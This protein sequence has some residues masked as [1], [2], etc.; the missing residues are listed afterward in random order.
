MLNKAR[1][2][3]LGDTIWLNPSKKL[4][5]FHKWFFTPFEDMPKQVFEEFKHHSHTHA[6][7]T[8]TSS[9]TSHGDSVATGNIICGASCSAYGHSHTAT[10]GTA[11][12]HTHSVTLSFGSANLGS[13]NWYEHTHSVAMVTCGSGGTIHTHTLPAS[14]TANYCLICGRTHTHSH[15]VGTL[16]V[17]SVDDSHTHTL[18]LNQVTG[19]A[20]SSQTPD[21]HQHPFSTGTT[22]YQDATHPTSGQTAAAT[23]YKGCSHTQPYFSQTD[24]SSHQHT[25][26]GD[27]GYGG[28][29]LP[30]TAPK[31]VGDGLTW[32]V[33]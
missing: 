10:L 11:D 23:C 13:P 17:S 20:Y 6:N 31:M 29:P 7:V 22:S 16:S 33:Y 9:T 15:G 27:S 12:S 4:L 2:L 32:L 25:L 28:E 19:N 21:S 5:G 3:R 14:T 18:L 8:V 1:H 30:V 24:G 26:A